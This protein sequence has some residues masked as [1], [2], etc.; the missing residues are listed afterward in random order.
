MIQPVWTPGKPSHFGERY[1]GYSP[2]LR[3]PIAFSSK[4]EF[5]WGLLHEFDPNVTSYCEQPAEAA[6]RIDGRWGKSR[7]D[8]W[9]QFTSGD[10][11]FEELKYATDLRDPESRAHRQIAIQQSWCE[12]MGVKHAVITDAEVWANPTLNNSLR[13]LVHE[14][15][16]R[17]PQ[18]VGSAERHFEAI[19]VSVGRMPGITI[20]DL[21]Q[22]RPGTA[23]V[24]VFRLAIFELIRCRILDARIEKQELSPLSPLN[25]SRIEG[26]K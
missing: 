7:F 8:F 18:L 25:I 21:L 22:S 4:L 19:S 2:K 14:Y 24:E 5:E 3:R 9:V 15:N 20:G 1:F 16:I 17:Y 12:L 6:A 10:C 23:P 13:A 26:E 11:R